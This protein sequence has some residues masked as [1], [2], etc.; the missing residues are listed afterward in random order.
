MRCINIEVRSTAVVVRKLETEAP[1]IYLV[2][3]RKTALLFTDY[4]HN[5]PALLNAARNSDNFP[6]N[7][8][9][10]Y[11]HFVLYSAMLLNA[12]I[13]QTVCLFPN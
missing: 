4:E 5:F 2:I 9:A 11:T 7:V 6:S 12:Q 8:W 10:V 3:H 1:V 13:V